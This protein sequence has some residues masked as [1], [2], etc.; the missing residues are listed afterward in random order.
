M[1]F[2]DIGRRPKETR[3]MA[4]GF[5]ISKIN[6]YIIQYFVFLGYVLQVVIEFSISDFEGGF[7]D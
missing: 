2:H 6:G 1:R 4:G 7:R 3:F 5:N